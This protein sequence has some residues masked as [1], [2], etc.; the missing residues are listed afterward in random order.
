MMRGLQPRLDP[1]ALDTRASTH[2]A[3]FARAWLGGFNLL[4]Y[5]QRNARLARRRR[6]LEWFAAALAGFAA[7]F[8]LVGWQAFERARL[9]AQRASIEQ[10][11]A[12]L[13]EPLAEHARLLRVQDEQR[14]GVA[15]AMNLSE[16]LTHLRDLLDALSFEPGD[17]VVL[18]QMR[19]REHETELLATSRGH[20]A[21]AEWL[22]RLSAIRGVKGA[23][24]SDLRRSAPRSSSVAAASVSGPIEFGAHL[25][26]GD[27]PKKTAHT[28]G[29]AAQRH[30]KSE[31]S[32]D[33][34]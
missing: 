9:D 4:P 32:G 13:A 1:A 24:V 22:K 3:R 31:P 14:K 5:R 30:M 27:P 34:K 7:V 19:Q 16:P 2:G 17:G 20:L 8:A 11:L 25:R 33:T 15:R 21:S 12:Q 10:S 26:W 23:E 28:S 29:L 6:L 18:Q